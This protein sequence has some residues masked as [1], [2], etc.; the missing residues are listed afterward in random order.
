MLGEWKRKW[1]QQ[2]LYRGYMGVILGIG[3]RDNY[4]ESQKSSYRDGCCDPFLPFLTNNL[5]E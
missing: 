3:Q 5:Q 4:R 1:I 2:G